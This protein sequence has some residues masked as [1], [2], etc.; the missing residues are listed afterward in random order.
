MEKKIACGAHSFLTQPVYSTGQIEQI[1]EATAHLETPV[2]LGI[3]PLTSSRNAEFIHNEVPGISL[4]DSVRTAMA[5]AGEDPVSAKREG[6]AIAMELIEAAREKF[7]GL[8]LITPLLQYDMTV[9][10][11]EYIREADQKK[12]AGVSVYD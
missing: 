12:E 4:P 3:M 10:L 6:L 5:K 11:T 1:S 2:F 9:R 7:N 8:Y